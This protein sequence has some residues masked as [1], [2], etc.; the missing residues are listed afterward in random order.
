MITSEKQKNPAYITPIMA[1]L[2]LAVPHRGTGNADSLSHF[3]HTLDKLLPAGTGPNRRYV[4][5][6]KLKNSKLASITDRFIQLL[7]GNGIGIISCYE[8]KDYAKGKGKVSTF[9]FCFRKLGSSLI[10][11]RL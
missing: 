11:H 9:T 2:F 4:K 1:C 3:L 10:R 6:L 8:D 7:N 5:D